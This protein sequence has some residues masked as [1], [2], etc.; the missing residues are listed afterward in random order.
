MSLNASPALLERA[1]TGVVPDSD[2]LECIAES[3]PYAWKVVRDVV[4]DMAD[5]RVVF[6]DDST[7]PPSDDAQGQLLRL[8]ASDAMRAVLERHYGVKLAFQNCCRVA[9]FAVTATDGEEY[10]EFVSARGQLLNQKPE[11]RNC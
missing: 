8:M 9:V 1:E 4:G 7:P 3:L 10:R 6:A 11:L 5:R 2:F